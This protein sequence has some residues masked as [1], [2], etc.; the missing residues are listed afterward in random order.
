MK[1]CDLVQFHSDLSGG[2]KRYINDKIAFCAQRDDIEH[3]VI[4]PAGHDRRR[5]EGRSRIYELRSPPLPGSRSYRLM[6]ARRRILS[7]LAEERPDV[8][9]GDDPYRLAWVAIEAGRLLNIPVVAFYHSDY[10]RALG[11]TLDRFGLRR[12]CAPATRLTERYLA[13]L[14]NRMSATIVATHAFEATL[15]RI[16]VAHVVRNP[17][18]IDAAVF[19]PRW[20]RDRVLDELDL[21]RGTR[22]LLHVGRLARE[23]NIAALCDMMDLLR[24]DPVPY[25]LLI[26][27]DGELRGLAQRRSRSRFNISWLHHCGDADRLADIYSAADLL[28]HAGVNETFGLTAAEAQACGTRVLGVKGG[29]LD[30]VLEGEHP[31]VMAATATAAAL[32]D[33]VRR[34][35]ALGES[36]WFRG[37]RSRRVS[38]MFAA[39]QTYTQLLDVYAQAKVRHAGMPCPTPP[40]CFGSFQGAPLHA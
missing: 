8:I 23:K 26:V 21:W 37:V 15:R 3:V 14:Y 13:G 2:V 30:D 12:L 24:D 38:R 18:G 25:H 6:P 1:I 4:V 16:G 5:T 20:S 36:D 27:G 34:V 32:A 40:A 31:C 9:E 17:L 33:G 28:V 29:G 35:T 22:L 7:I 11:R 39:G 10:P 19:R